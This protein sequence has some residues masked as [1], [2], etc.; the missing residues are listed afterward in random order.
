VPSLQSGSVLLINQYLYQHD[1]WDEELIDARGVELTN[2]I[3][4]T[5]PGPSADVWP[6]A[7]PPAQPVESR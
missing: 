7:A 3:L 6:V 2:R 1:D 5:W 4:R